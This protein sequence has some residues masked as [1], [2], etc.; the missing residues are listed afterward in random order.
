MDDDPIIL[1]ATARALRVIGHEVDTA[2]D[3][4]SAVDRYREALSAGRRYDVVILD[5]SAG[6][7]HMG[8][9][10][11]LTRLVT[12]DPSVRAVISSGEDEDVLTDRLGG[13]FRG[14]LKKPYNRATLEAVLALSLGAA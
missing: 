9:V 12:I 4:E 14:A 1:R 11:A 5:V 3:G 8:G 2:P 7:S 10:E 13:G 6:A